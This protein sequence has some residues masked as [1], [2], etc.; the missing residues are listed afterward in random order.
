M[1]KIG[2]GDIQIDISGGTS[3]VFFD[4]KDDDSN[5]TNELQDIFLATFSNNEVLI[6]IENG[7]SVAFSIDDSDPDPF[8]EIQELDFNDDGIGFNIGLRNSGIVQFWEAPFH[9][10]KPINLSGG[11]GINI[12]NPFGSDVVQIF[13]N[14]GGAIILNSIDQQ[15]RNVW[16]TNLNGFENNGFLGVS[17]INNNNV[18]GAFVDANGD[19]LLFCTGAKHFKMDYPGKA[20]KSIWYASVEGPEAA[21]YERGTAT[22]ENGEIFVP[23]SDHFQLVIA[24]KGMT[25]ML[26]P[27]SGESQGLAVVEKTSEGFMVKELHKGSGNYSFDWEVKCVRAGFENYQVIRERSFGMPANSEIK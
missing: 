9:P 20:D 19:G 13:G 14:G 21:A 16:L 15:S 11:N 17:D 1:R 3:D 7:N 6:E 5:P 18:A 2:N 4:V 25:V 26:T 24:K 8:N 23:F 10:M 22:L 12:Q 27:L